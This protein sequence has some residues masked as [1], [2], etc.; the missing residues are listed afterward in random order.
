MPTEPHS[1][2]DDT[3]P[4]VVFHDERDT[5][6]ARAR[7]AGLEVDVLTGG[8]QPSLIVAFPNGRDKW[9]FSVPSMYANVLLSYHFETWTVLGRYR[10]VFDKSQAAIEAN[11]GE[12]EFGGSWASLGERLQHIEGVHIEQIRRL[13]VPPEEFT[14]DF[15]FAGIEYRGN[16]GQ[17]S[18]WRLAVRDAEAPFCINIAPASPLLAVVHP[19]SIQYASIG[20][21]Y[22][23]G[24][25]VTIKPV[26]QE[27]HDEA[28]EF[29]ERVTG[30][31]FFEM[32]LRNNI[33]LCL[34]PLPLDSDAT[35]QTRRP[36][37]S[38]ALKLPRNQ[39]SSEALSLYSYGLSAVG[40]PLLE[41][42]AFYQVIEHFFPRFT[43]EDLLRRL[44]RRLS[45]PRFST[46]D[47]DKLASIVKIVQSSSPASLSEREQL[48]ATLIACTE[49]ER[50]REFLVEVKERN[51]F[52]R[53]KSKLGGVQP[54]IDD[55]RHDDLTAQIASR[56]YD[57][58]CRIVHSKAERG[59]KQM[60][61]ILPFSSAADELRHDVE[62]VR[63]LAQEVIISSASDR[64]W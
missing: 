2:E 8:A 22:Y 30:A 45:D 54:I 27:R 38:N 6:A 41:F 7:V 51:E 23:K 49:S 32:D 44:A 35:L 48:E 33:G 50:C 14:D 53:N 28:L 42:L 24:I 56:V 21:V 37:K 20:K 26:R 4:G 1:G 19:S 55:D 5:V 59:T 61:S 43:S 40:M 47:L 31:L 18:E 39:Y 3:S 9:R 52:L 15:G 16:A 10:A 13:D 11:I 64:L 62:L 29:L 58:R 60:E 63:F 12:L 25:S 36:K 17:R 34:L 57:I 46:D